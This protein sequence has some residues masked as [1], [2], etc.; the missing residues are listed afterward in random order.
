MSSR[1]DYQILPLESTNF[2]YGKA[3]QTI[4]CLSNPGQAFVFWLGAVYVIPLM[5][6]FAQFYSQAYR[7]P[8]KIKSL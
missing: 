2:Q 3:Y 1:I 4:S 7:T 5:Y 8:V 6:L